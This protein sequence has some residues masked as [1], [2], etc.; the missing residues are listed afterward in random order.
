MAFYQ[1]LAIFPSLLVLLAVAARVP[2]LGDFFK[3]LLPD[4]SEQVLPSQVA[5]L[6]ATMTDELSRRA[7]SGFHFVVVCAGALW[8][9]GNA[10]WAMVHGLNRAYELEER[11]SPWRLGLTIG[12]LTLS[13]ELTTCMAL[14]LMFGGA[15]LEGHFR[16]GVVVF[17]GL[18]WLTLVV[19][20]SFSFALLY[21]FAPS[22]RD[23]EW[24]WSTP[25]AVCALILWG[26]AT[27]AARMYFERVDDYSFT[28]GQL[29]GVVMLLLWLYV[30]NGA[31][32][33]GG[34]MNSEIEK[35]ADRSASP[36]DRSSAG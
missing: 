10:T 19:C 35:A 20:L 27:F 13:L 21:R 3:R 23:R 30:T 2:H 9:A 6:F 4:L 34:E 32:L 25:G 17:R 8:A 11:R 18:E 31:V 5:L 33:I 14:L 16:A 26:A 36:A 28:Y 15:K 22:L 7:L 24:R 29:N 1:F 12:G